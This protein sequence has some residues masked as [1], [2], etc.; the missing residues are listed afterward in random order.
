VNNLHIITLYKLHNKLS[1]ESRLS[2]SSCQTSRARRVECDE[3]ARHSKMHGFDTSNVS[4]RVVSRRCEPSGILALL[5]T[6]ATF[7]SLSCKSSETVPSQRMTFA[8]LMVRS[9]CDTRY[10]FIY[11]FIIN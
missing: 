8:S 7:V 3:R 4:S 2:R 6:H 11:L 5:S 9:D 1:C 10:Y